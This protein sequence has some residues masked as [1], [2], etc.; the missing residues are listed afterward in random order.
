MRAPALVEAEQGLARALVFGV[1][2][3]AARQRLAA[4]G[5]V[6]TL[7]PGALL[8]QKG[9]P[10]D[11]AYLVLEGELEVRTV[12]ARGRLVRLAA[13][14]RGEIAGEMAVLD[15]A[16]RSADM[17]AVRRTRLLKLTRTSLMEALAAEPRAAIALIE[18][19]TRR[20]RETDEALE[21]LHLLDLGGRLATL[22]VAE[23]GAHGIV[24]LTQAELAHRIG[25]S[26]EKV[27]RQLGRWRREG[28][29]SVTKAGVRV[30]ALDKL[31]AAIQTT[32][33]R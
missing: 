29:V 9:D 27:N 14:G 30:I 20:L 17:V 15:G 19:L 1:L 6:M 25:A 2:S 8:C 23:A 10:G 4:G 12:S 22:L 3:E 18:A 32:Q 33:R 5:Q 13:L 11:A 26:R 28:L 21:A 24:A 31:R 16:A 7:S